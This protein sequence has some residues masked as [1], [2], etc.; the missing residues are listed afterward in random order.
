MIAT[1]R[2]RFLIDSALALRWLH[3]ARRGALVVQGVVMGLAEVGTGLHL[4][5]PMLVLLLVA[6]AAIDRLQTLLHPS[7]QLV[8]VHAALDLCMLTAILAL[9]GGPSNPLVSAYL[10]YLALLAIVLPPGWA[11]VSVGA[12]VGLQLL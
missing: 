3:R 8:V 5:S 7:E 6:W 1:E 11:W 9:S 12:A 4:H 10:V 2:D